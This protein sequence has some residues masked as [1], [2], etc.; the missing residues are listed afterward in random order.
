MNGRYVG[1]KGCSWFFEHTGK[2]KGCHKQGC[3]EKMG[4]YREM[5][6]RV[7]RGCVIW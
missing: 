2:K 1:N 5:L 7:V 6:G 4:L 3:D